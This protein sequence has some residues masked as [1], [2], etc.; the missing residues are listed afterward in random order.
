[1]LTAGKFKQP[2]GMERL[3]F[4]ANNRFLELGLPSDIVPNRD[5]GLMLSGIFFD[6]RITYQIGWFNASAL[7]RAA[8][9]WTYPESS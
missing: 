8:S 4:S 9:H 1:M 6:D 5:L 2:F 7:D 3:Q